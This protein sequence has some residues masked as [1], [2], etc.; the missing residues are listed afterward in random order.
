MSFRPMFL[1]YYLMIFHQPRQ[2][3]L[4]LD[5]ALLVQPIA[6][7]INIESIKKSKRKK[8]R[9]NNKIQEIQKSFSN[10]HLKMGMRK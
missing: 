1:S 10:K 7:M 2:S 9:A 8:K 6:A 5:L 4:V 3:L